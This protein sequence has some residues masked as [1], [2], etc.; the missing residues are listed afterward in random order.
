MAKVELPMSSLDLPGNSN[1]MKEAAEEKP[2]VKK[3]VKGPVVIKKPSVG[4]RLSNIFLG[5]NATEVK[6]YIF[7]DVIIPS[8]KDLISDVITGGIDMLLYGEHCHR[9]RSSNSNSYVSYSNY[10]N[11]GRPQ[12]KRRSDRVSNTPGHTVK[13]IIFK[14]REEA[15]DVLG[16]MMDQIKDYGMVSVGDLYD[17]VGHPELGNITT[18]SWGWFNLDGARVRGTNGGYIIMLPKTE[19]LK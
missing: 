8:L 19:Y 12:E 18:E 10:Y 7:L 14:T 9:G 5:E 16:D 13:E 3:V 15:G 6:S 11:G 4:Q 17:M 1:S 2:R